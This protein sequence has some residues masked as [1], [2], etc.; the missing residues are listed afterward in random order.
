MERFFYQCRAIREEYELKDFI[1]QT[2]QSAATDILKMPWRDAAQIVAEGRKRAQKH[3]FW[4]MYCS[5]YPH[6]NEDNFVEFEA[7]FEG[8]KNKTEASK[9]SADEIVADVNSIIAMTV[10]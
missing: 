7:W 5:M 9:K 10:K 6:M 3:D 8:L 1:Y 2:Y 4:L